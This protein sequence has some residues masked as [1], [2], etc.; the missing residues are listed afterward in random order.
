MQHYF[1]PFHFVKKCRSVDWSLDSISRTDGYMEI[2]LEHLAVLRF[3][4]KEKVREPVGVC[5]RGGLEGDGLD[6]CGG[7]DSTAKNRERECIA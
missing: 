3:S 4:V 7:R 1:R 6:I 2:S 5:F